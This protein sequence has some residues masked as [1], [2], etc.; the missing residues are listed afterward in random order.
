MR[1]CTREFI[2]KIIFYLGIAAKRKGNLRHFFCLFCF[3]S[4]GSLCIF[5]AAYSFG[6]LPHLVTAAHTFSSYWT[7]PF[8]MLIALFRFEDYFTYIFLLLLFIVPFSLLPC[9]ARL[10]SKFKYF[11]VLAIKREKKKQK[12]FNK[13][14]TLKSSNVILYSTTSNLSLVFETSIKATQKSGF[15]CREQRNILWILFDCIKRNMT[16]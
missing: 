11:V 7:F 15:V 4:F 13:C 6:F 5:Y 14:E 1:E 3:I 2:I 8:F 12:Q 9:R 16:H 10:A